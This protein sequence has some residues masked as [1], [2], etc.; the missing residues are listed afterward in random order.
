MI[1]N[2]MPS[3]ILYLIVM[4]WQMIISEE[5]TAAIEVNS[6]MMPD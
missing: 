5:I 3:I 4:I 2:K 6:A 1:I